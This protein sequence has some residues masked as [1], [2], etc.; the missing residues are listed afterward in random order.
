MESL[1]EEQYQTKIRELEK[2]VK[3]LNLIIQKDSKIKYGLRWIDVPEA[4][5][6]ESENKIPIL[7][8]VKDKAIKSNDGK[9]T[10]ILIEGDNY[11]ALKCLNYTHKGKIDVIYIDP[12]YNTEKGEFIY[13]DKRVLESFPDGSP[14]TKD[15]PLRHS[16][17]LSFMS[18]RLELAKNLLSDSGVIFISIDDNEQANLK[19]L[20]DQIFGRENFQT[21]FHVLVR[22][23]DKSLT[24]DKPFK[25]LMEYI[26]VYS[27]NSKAFSP[28]RETEDYG[29]EKFCF[30]ISEIKEGEEY[31]IGNQ[32]VKVFKKG[33]WKLEKVPCSLK[34]LKETW[35]TGTIY[36]TMS[37]GKVF[38]TY[39]EPRIKQDGLGCLYK[40]LG[41][42]DDGLGYRYY[43]GPAK[44]TAKFGKMYSGMP[45]DKVEEFKKGLNPQRKLAIDTVYDFA[46]DFGNIST[47]GGVS[48]NGG[49]KPIVMLKKFIDLHLD[50][51][52]TVL[53]FF[54]GSGST[55]HA[56]IA[57]NEI[58]KGHRQCILV[59]QNEK[60]E[61]I[62]EIKTFARCKNVMSEYGNSLKY[63]RTAFVGENE[64]EYATDKDKIALSKKA[65]CLLSM[66]ENT[67]EE[68]VSTDRYQIFGNDKNLFTGIYFSANADKIHEFA[69]KLEQL[70]NLSPLNMVNAY[71]FTSSDGSEFQSEFESLKNIK[72]KSIPEPILEV[73]RRLN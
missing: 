68:Y 66:A 23:A 54:A 14:I 70:R 2:E 57:Q 60:K 22:Y 61:K 16:S 39:I 11:H 29:L 6:K 32:K 28:N 42:G 20:C 73:Y 49:K 1:T 43:T 21:I 17:W 7:E 27:K 62:C 72:I 51:D 10:H 65:G 53:D 33:E 52:A 67:L 50:K 38:Q 46:A 69:A 71:F 8:E 40:V 64:A 36:S 31:Q 55:L 30:A 35:I 37:Y 48:Y 3:K 4:F 5:E 24:D 45:L 44:K 18:K 59:Q 34:G 19:L 9:P 58:D 63:Y 12:P 13:K 25:P 56:T 26:L 41:R 15:H 47:E